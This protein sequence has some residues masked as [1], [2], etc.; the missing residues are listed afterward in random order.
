MDIIKLNK[1]QIGLDKNISYN[2]FDIWG[3]RIIEDKESII[4]QIPADDVIFIRYKGK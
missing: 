2:L 3:K 4:F 1:E